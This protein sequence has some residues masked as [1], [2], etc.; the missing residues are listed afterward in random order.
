MSVQLRDAP[1][2]PREEV[3]H[4]RLLARKLASR[5]AEL[6]TALDSR[7]VIEQAKGLLAERFGVSVEEAFTLLRLAARSNHL[8]LHSLAAQIVVSRATPPEVRR[9]RRRMVTRSGA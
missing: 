3:I 5:A 4:L 6:Q 1:A 9:E 2:D 8:E 7:V